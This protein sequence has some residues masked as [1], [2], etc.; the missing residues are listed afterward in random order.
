MTTWH[1]PPDV[2]T[3]F[4]LEP[5]A[6]DDVTASS[7]E[8]H[9]VA[10]ETCRAAVSSATPASELEASWVEIVDRVDRPKTTFS[11]RLLTRVG[12]PND[13]ARV[14]GA[15]PGL[16][17]AWLATIAFLALGAVQV[18]RQRDTE[19]LF[20]VVAPLLPLGSVL[21]TFLPAEEP[22]GEAA[23]ATPLHG[24]GV[25]IRRAAAALVPTFLIL[26]AA[27]VALPHVAEG[28]RWLLPGLA[29]AL[30]S[31]VLATWIRPVL[32]VAAVAATWVGTL[33][34]VRVAEARSIPLDR[35][36]VF[37]LQGQLVALAVALIAAVLLYARRDRFST[38]EVT[39]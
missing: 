5:E 28:A 1:A 9:L 11:E 22:G 30:G 8:Q 34:A 13:L 15:T 37:E 21:V 32:A 24:A 7:V 12:M 23:S 17:L 33:V 20:L 3:R 4:A 31:L 16:R 2:L 27:S 36:V 26:A 29:L 10:C 14:V 35:T 25:V 19:V 6:L 38:V 18:A 39:W